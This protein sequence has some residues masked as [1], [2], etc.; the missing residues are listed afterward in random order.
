MRRRSLAG[1]LVV[2][3]LAAAGCQRAAAPEP[4]NEETTDIRFRTVG[5]ALE[6]GAQPV[7]AYQVELEVLTGDA[8]IV[9]VEGGS[10]EGFTDPPY[11]DPAALAGGRIVVAALSARTALSAGRHQVATVHLRE[12]GRQPTYRLR[13]ITA[14]DPDARPAEASAVL[15]DESPSRP[16]EEP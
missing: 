4:G 7:A 1:A 12:R 16:E 13:L 11:Y 2:A 9:G 5:I 14:G 3:L 15:L 6:V 10:A 8:R